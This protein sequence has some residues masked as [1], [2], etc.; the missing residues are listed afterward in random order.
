MMIPQDL[1]DTIVDPR[2]YQ[3]RSRSDEAFRRGDEKAVAA[4]QPVIGRRPA[5]VVHGHGEDGEATQQVQA[6]VTFAGFEVA[7]GSGQNRSLHWRLPSPT[8]TYQ[9][10]NSLCD[11]NH[12]TWLQPTRFRQQSAIG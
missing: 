12:Y 4:A 6:E 8:D 11:P 2:A 5:N 1:A 10:P 7:P 3:D 9:T